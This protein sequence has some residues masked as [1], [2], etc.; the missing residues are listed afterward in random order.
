MC[1]CP[2]VCVCVCVCLCLCVCMCVLQCV[3]IVVCNW[4]L[5][6]FVLSSRA[7][8]IV[9][10]VCS[11]QQRTCQT[12]NTCVSAGKWLICLCCDVPMHAHT[13][14]HFACVRVGRVCCILYFHFITSSRLCLLPLPPNERGTKTLKQKYAYTRGSF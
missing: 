5:M 8:P 4:C 13:S 14:M 12:Q 1:V 2:C 9:F 3:C 6:Q 10:A 7:I 11:H